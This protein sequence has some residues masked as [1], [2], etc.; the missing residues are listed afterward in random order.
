[1]PRYLGISPEPNHEYYTPPDLVTGNRVF[2]T[3]DGDSGPGA[4]EVLKGR[5]SYKNPG[6]AGKMVAGR[7]ARP[8]LMVRF[9]LISIL[10]KNN[11]SDVFLA[12]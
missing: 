10:A 11:I 6:K 8:P 9:Q 12:K 4:R 5:M 3:V 2:R 1:M 7:I